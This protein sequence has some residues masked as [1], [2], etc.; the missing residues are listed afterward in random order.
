M[1]VAGGQDPYEAFNLDEY[2]VDFGGNDDPFGNIASVSGLVPK[3]KL[4]VN[5]NTR[6]KTS[7][8]HSKREE[9]PKK[10]KKKHVKRSHSSSGVSRADKKERRRSH[11]RH[12]TRS[13]SRESE[14][15]SRRSVSVPSND[16]DEV[17]ARFQSRKPPTV[18]TAP[19]VVSPSPPPLASPSPVAS[20]TASNMR[21]P[22]PRFGRAQPRFSSSYSP[23]GGLPTMPPSPEPEDDVRSASLSITQPSPSIDESPAAPPK[24]VYAPVSPVPAPRS[25]TPVSSH[26]P[27]PSAS[28]SG[29][30][31][32]SRPRRIMQAP[33]EAP[34]YNEVS[35]PP[36]TLPP[37]ERSPSPASASASASGKETQRV[38][39]PPASSASSASVSARSGRSE[40][41]VS[42]RSTAA[43]VSEAVPQ[44]TV[45]SAP[46]APVSV[47]TQPVAQ[48][49]VSTTAPVPPQ[50]SVPAQA[51]VPQGMP[52]AASTAYGTAYGVP[53]Q[54]QP[55]PHQHMPTPHMPAFV[56]TGAAPA[57]A[58]LSADLLTHMAALPP[59]IQAAQGGHAQRAHL[60]AHASY[61][62]LLQ[63]QLQSLLLAQYSGLATGISAADAQAGASQGMGAT[64]GRS[65]CSCPMCGVGGGATGTVPQ[66]SVYGVPPPPQTGVPPAPPSTYAYHPPASAPVPQTQSEGVGGVPGEA[67][68][69]VAGREGE[70]GAAPQMPPGQAGSADY[71]QGGYT[72]TQTQPAGYRP[73]YA[74]ATTT[75]TRRAPL[76]PGVTRWQR[77][78]Q[79][80]RALGNRQFSMLA[81]SSLY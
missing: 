31:R 44:S 21:L 47:P 25:A 26:S 74:T 24:L 56:P 67:D 23:D 48:Q 11:R 32:V 30:V 12:R 41:A 7:K 38:T 1:F 40:P 57:V 9:K 79:S 51:Q 27:S 22:G 77:T 45:T 78:R 49:A 59:A 19:A 6:A 71:P 29:P 35:I 42:A 69:P 81:A 75:P 80:D 10:E 17:P 66:P 58:S 73:L 34:S 46:A 28:D 60:T 13:P 55:M 39:P 2:E 52:P 15:L 20:Y 62:A 68:S 5:M 4:Q 70:V 3:R 18:N 61:L 43:S 65:A 16:S 53:P 37:K 36:V 14:E 72:Q 76:L 63:T 50:V 54:T 8:P 33:A 64:R